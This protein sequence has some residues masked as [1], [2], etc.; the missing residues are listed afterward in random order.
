MTRLLLAGAVLLLVAPP[1]LASATE[2]DVADRLADDIGGAAARLHR[3]IAAQQLEVVTEA[4]PG[5][6]L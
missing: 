6:A 2:Q 3:S 5:E 4:E 1:A